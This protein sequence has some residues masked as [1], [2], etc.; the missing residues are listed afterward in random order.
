MNDLWWEH[1]CPAMANIGPLKEAQSKLIALGVDYGEAGKI[2]S[3]VHKSY[4]DAVYDAAERYEKS[5][6]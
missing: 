4:V 1:L 6:E 5:K 2:L 3:A